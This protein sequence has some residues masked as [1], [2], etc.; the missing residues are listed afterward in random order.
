MSKNRWSKPFNGFNCGL[1]SVAFE[2][3]TTD[4]SYFSDFFHGGVQASEARTGLPD[5][6]QAG[7]S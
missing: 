7:S 1:D 3:L 5:G 2:S 6:E 4:A